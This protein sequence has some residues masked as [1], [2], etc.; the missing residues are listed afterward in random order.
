MN[1]SS[2]PYIAMM[3]AD[4]RIANDPLLMS[5]LQSNSDKLDFGGT[6]YQTS[7]NDLYKTYDTRRNA[8][9]NYYK[10]QED[11]TKKKADINT[12]GDTANYQ[13]TIDSLNTGLIED[14]DTLADQEGI[15]GTWGSSARSE[16]QNSLANKYNEKYNTAYNT[17]TTNSGLDS[18][19]NQQLLG[20]N[21]YSP[22]FNKYQATS[23]GKPVQVGQTYKYNPFQQ[24]SGSIA[25][26]RAY[27]LGGL[28]TGK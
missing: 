13:N 12:M 17:I 18:V 28:S 6:P 1:T 25:G 11:A 10:E 4:P 26:N 21:F 22:T 7:A 19:N 8:L 23:S 15:K 3:M 5:V 20:N 2:N 14:T 24:K 27:S 16:R 9:L